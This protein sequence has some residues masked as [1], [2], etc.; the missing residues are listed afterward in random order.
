MLASSSL[1]AN[2]ESVEESD[3]QDERWRHDASHRWKGKILIALHNDL[4]SLKVVKYLGRNSS[5]E[6]LVVGRSSFAGLKEVYRY[7]GDEL[8]R[9]ASDVTIWVME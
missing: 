1:P 3:S 7:V 9:K 8:V 4:T 6:T 2:Y 5:G